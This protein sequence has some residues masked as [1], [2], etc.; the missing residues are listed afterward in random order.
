[1]SEQQHSQLLVDLDD[2]CQ[3]DSLSEDG[4]RAIIQRHGWTPNNNTSVQ[5]Y[6]FFLWACENER[7]TMGIL[8]YLLHN[9]PGAATFINTNWHDYINGNTALHVICQNDNVTLGMVHILLDAF[10]ESVR[11][12][13][14]KGNMPLHCLCRNRC[15]DDE[16]EVPRY[17]DEI[18]VDILKLLLERCPESVRHV[19]GGE[20]PIHKA[21]RYQSP[22]FCRILIEAYPE[23][24]RMAN[25]K[26]C[27][28]FHLAC[29]FNSHATA[30]YLYQLFPESINVAATCGM[31]PI[32]C[33]IACLTGK[34]PAKS[35][36]LVR[37]LLDCNPDVV[38]QECDGIL[39]IHRIC[40]IA[41]EENTRTNLNTAL[42]ILQI[43]YDAH[44][45]A[46]ERNAVTTDLDSFP[47]EVRRFINN[48][49]VYAR[50]ARDLRQM[51]TPDKN[52][53]L[54]LHRALRDNVDLGSI[55]ML[56][57]S[58]PS[59]ICNFDKRGKIP[60]HVA[61]QH[62]KSAD[63]VQYLIE[64]GEDTLDT[65]DKEG[66]TALHYACRGA[67]H[68]TIALLLDRYGAVSVSKENVRNQIPIDLLFKSE[69]VSDR[70]GIEYTESIFRLLRAYPDTINCICNKMPQRATSR[71]QWIQPQNTKKRKA[72]S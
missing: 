72:D 51:N 33:V 21:A 11:H 24:E 30:E 8:R 12:E 6:N 44:P 9:F 38:L 60:L 23:S 54:P 57:K 15:E 50:Q 14:K 48:R 26:G 40:T 5:N 1:M 41:N 10:P 13:A 63:A 3:S 64:L 37:F 42:K 17:W 59:A 53:Q 61:S 58:N 31:Y 16:E 20:L 18:A 43:L 71:E 29:A 25:N 70:E 46:I 35:I 47:Q 34:N 22:E 62:H 66:N 65:M 68:K 28:P 7:V 69:A 32:T 52:G 39:P 55:K 19:Q 36:E 45:E 67:K 56:V 4:L 27:L 49:L 2:L